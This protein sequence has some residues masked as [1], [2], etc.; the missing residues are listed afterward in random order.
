MTKNTISQP[1]LSHPIPLAAYYASPPVK[2]ITIASQ[3]EVSGAQAA[4]PAITTIVASLE[5]NNAAKR[6]PI[7]FT[8]DRL[9][10]P[11]IKDI[12]QL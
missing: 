2:A 5:I 1:M 9:L 4:D 6:P 3:D 10:Y 7:F 8:E 12:K 11:Q